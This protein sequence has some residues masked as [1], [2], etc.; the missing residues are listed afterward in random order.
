M[1]RHMMIVAA[2][3]LGAG[4]GSFLATR[5]VQPAAAG[6]QQQTEPAD[7]QAPGRGRSLARWLELSPERQQAVEQAD[8]DFSAE[9]AELRQTLVDE[10]IRLAALLENLDTPDEP[11][12]EQVERVIEAHDK[13]ER[14]IARHVLAIR[15][16]LTPAQQRELMSVCAGCVRQA[17]GWRMC[18]GQGCGKGAGGCDKA[19]PGCC[20][21]AGPPQCINKQAP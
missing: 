14:R 4:A 15:P 17:V 18:R 8:P 19:G 12:L 21:G 11:I 20:R 5:A 13:L 10:R 1:T 16:H 9:S 2:L 7:V 6:P 3:A